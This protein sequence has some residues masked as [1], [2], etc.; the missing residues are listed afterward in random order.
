MELFSG[1]ADWRLV[2]FQCVVQPKPSQ[3]EST[4]ILKTK[5]KNTVDPNHDDDDNYKHSKKFVP[6]KVA[7]QEWQLSG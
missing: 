3:L 4:I 7:M 2:C 1:I 5:L 6:N